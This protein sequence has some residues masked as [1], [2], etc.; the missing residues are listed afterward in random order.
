MELALGSFLFTLVLAIP[1]GLI[2]AAKQYTPTDN[3][4]T[5]AAFFGISMPNFWLALLLIML[6][7][8]H[9]PNLLHFIFDQ[10]L[11]WVTIPESFTVL[12]IAGRIG[13]EYQLCGEPVYLI[14][15]LLMRDF[16]AFGRV[17]LPT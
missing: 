11:G 13:L 3:V 2:G 9:L 16:R 12:P 4:I 17:P 15:T 6:F 10:T 7:A 5:F 8:F 1:A 14:D